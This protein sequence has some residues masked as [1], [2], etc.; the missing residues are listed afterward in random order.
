L[1][2]AELELELELELEE[3]DAEGRKELEELDGREGAGAA[4]LTIAAGRAGVDWGARYVE[5]DGVAVDRGGGED[6]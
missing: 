5:L 3:L 2:L 6:R 1:L 4:G